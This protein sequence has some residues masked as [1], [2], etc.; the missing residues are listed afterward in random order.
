MRCLLGA[1]VGFLGRLSVCLS[2]LPFRCSD[3]VFG[4]LNNV[5]PGGVKIAGKSSYS[6]SHKHLCISHLKS[7]KSN[8]NPSKPTAYFTNRQTDYRRITKK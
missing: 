7:N 3:A 6:K 4:D 2:C 1:C 8:S 5:A